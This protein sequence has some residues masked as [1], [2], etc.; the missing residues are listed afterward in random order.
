MTIE[1][2]S[3]VTGRA[4]K[5]NARAFGKLLHLARLHGWSAERVSGEWPS[6]SWDTEIILP[7]LGPYIPGTVTKADADGLRKALIRASATGE[8][9]GDGTIQFSAQTLMQLT[10]DGGFKVRL[11]ADETVEPVPQ[12]SPWR[13]ALFPSPPSPSLSAS[14]HKSA[15][16]VS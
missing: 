3:V 12:D 10:R 14:I 1:L 8:I 16:A 9:A 15:D 11:I 13:K 7:H 4:F 5:L 6:E 2:V